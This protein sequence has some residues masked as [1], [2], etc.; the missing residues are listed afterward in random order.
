MMEEHRNFLR[1]LKDLSYEEGD[2]LLASGKR[3]TFFIDCKE[4]TLTPRGCTLSATA[5]TRK[6]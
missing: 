2:F 1:L 4:T 3:S 5:C 6:Y